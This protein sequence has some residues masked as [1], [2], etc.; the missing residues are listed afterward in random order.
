[1]K[2]D[3]LIVGA[4]LFGS[5]FAHEANKRGYRC[6][7]IDKRK[8]TG[9]NTYCEKVQ[10]INVHS[11]G[12]HVFHTDNRDV[13]HYVNGFVP[14]NSFINTP[15]AKYRD[16]IYNLPFNMNT[17]HQLW[18]VTQPHEAEAIIKGQ[19]ADAGI[20]NPSNLE[21][22]AISMV[23]SDIYEKLIKGYTEKQWGRKANEL[24]SFIIRRLPI[25]YRFD[26]NY[27]NDKYQG[28]PQGGYNLLIEGL[29]RG[30]EV[31]L[32]VDFFDHRKELEQIAER[33]V[34]T[35]MID[36]L[37][38]YRY[39]CLAYR[40]LRFDSEILEMPD[41]QGNAIVNF[42]DRDT[43][44]TRIVEHKHFEFGQQDRT[45]ITREYPF[46]WSKGMEPF[47][48]IN[49]AFNNQLYLKYKTLADREPNLILGGR[50]ADYQYYDMDKVIDKALSSWKQEE[51]L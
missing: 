11:Y 18:G 51:A 30:T 15:L 8:H 45:I 43:P 24:P 42:T 21:E 14:F 49:D 16:E 10:G 17:F 37:F 22:Q 50:L 7:V 5:V 46:E 34:F 33:I 20:I 31:S 6:L 41:Y 36:Q 19:I 9:G 1:M 35:G 13:W 12:P 23:G 48:P 3:Y 44:F 29:L 39:G 2:Y 4:G 27:Y 26:N 38:D 47:Y 28:V 25:R 40:S 32:D